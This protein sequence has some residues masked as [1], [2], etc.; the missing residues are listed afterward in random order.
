MIIL[1]KINVEN[2]ANIWGGQSGQPEFEKNGK[3][4]KKLYTTYMYIF[5]YGKIF[6]GK[7]KKATNNKQYLSHLQYIQDYQFVIYEFLNKSHMF[8]E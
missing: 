5:F 7:E 4:K 1:Q 3:K 8:L 6:Y 2:S